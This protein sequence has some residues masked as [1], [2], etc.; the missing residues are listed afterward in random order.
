MRMRIVSVIACFLLIVS[1]TPMGIGFA[2]TV[3]SSEAPT[4]L[5]SCLDRQLLCVNS[6]MQLFSGIQ[7]R[8][9]CIE[10]CTSTTLSCN[11]YVLGLGG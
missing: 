4:T 11:K 8:Y 7:S 5:G 1:A 10:N 3:S 2:E 9:E 6:C